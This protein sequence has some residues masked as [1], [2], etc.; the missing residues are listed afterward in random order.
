MPLSIQ[1]RHAVLLADRTGDVGTITIVVIE[2]LAASL[3]T[4]P[5]EIETALRHGAAQSYLIAG[6]RLS[7]VLGLPAMLHTLAAAGSTPEQNRAALVAR[8]D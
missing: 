1:H 7:I 6:E 8:T 2:V 4:T 5:L 3:E